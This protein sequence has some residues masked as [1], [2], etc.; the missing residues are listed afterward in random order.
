MLKSF[1]IRCFVA[2]LILTAAAPAPSRRGIP[3]P[4]S[5]S[6]STRSPVAM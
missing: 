4:C 1:A 6:C 5:S 3:W 2:L